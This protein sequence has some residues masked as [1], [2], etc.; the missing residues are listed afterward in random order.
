MA[1][2]IV[3]QPTNIQAAYRPI[4]LE[5][6]A[7]TSAD[8]IPPVVYCDIYVAGIYY[9]TLSKTAFER[10][11]ADLPVYRFDIQDALQE[12]MSYN[13]PT[14]DGS[15]AELMTGTS[16]S[17][18]ARFRNA[19]YD[20]DG[21]IAS[22]Y[23]EPVRGTST[24]DPIAG[25]GEESSV[26]DVFNVTLQHEENQSLADFLE[27]YKTGTWSA[28]A[29]P[30]TKRPKVMKL[31]KSDSSFFP[32]LLEAEPAKL[33]LTYISGGVS[34]T[35]CANLIV[36]PP[37][38]VCPVILDLSYEISP[39]YIAGIQ[40]IVFSGTVD[41]DPHLTVDTVRLYYREHGTT[42]YLFI[43]EAYDPLIGLIG[44]TVSLGKWDFKI[45]LL[46]PTCLE[47]EVAETTVDNIGI[48]PACPIITGLEYTNADTFDGNQIFTFSGNVA[49]PHPS[50]ALLSIWHR[51][52]GGGFWVS[53]DM[54]LGPD[55]AFSEA[56]SL[57]LGQ[58]DFMLF[59]SG[60]E[61]TVIDGDPQFEAIGILEHN[62]CVSWTAE[63]QDNIK[64]AISY[65]LNF[66]D[67]LAGR[68]VNTG[69][70]TGSITSY[71]ID[72]ALVT[73]SI[74]LTISATNAHVDTDTLAVVTGEVLTEV[75]VNIELIFTDASE[76]TIASTTSAAEVP[77]AMTSEYNDCE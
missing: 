13:L 34:T 25:D 23:A 28:S 65:V 70:S 72:G 64:M 74:P 55:E 63:N 41:P 14:M 33:C 37:P 49:T 10:M 68:T 38:L 61:C 60:D 76:L 9:K 15:D 71:R 52:A 56:V 22:E 27:S 58:Y 44:I 57:P 75:T 73:V 53:T 50:G 18:F 29:L 7:T 3:T 6:T 30:M 47:G 24:T 35:V 67:A 26:F 36:P 2:T 20:A 46:G 19:I 8:T 51:P 77:G 45:V 69:V 39:N 21:F 54:A 43:D 32:I 40:A 16:K 42:D 11:D 66:T 17:V 48:Y 5:C 62:Y 31:C 12:L 4:I 1:I 59:I